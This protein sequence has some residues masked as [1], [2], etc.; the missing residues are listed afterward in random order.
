M[1][2]SENT[3]LLG[4]VRGCLYGGAVG[5]A[6]GAPAEGRRPEE[7]RDRYHEITGFVEPWNGPS[8]L[9]K[10]DGRY[11]DDTHMVQVLSRLYIEEGDHLDVFR[12]AR[13]IVPLI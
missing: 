1:S 4:K 3:A 11:T 8:E 7:I 6:L 10:G 5:D 2:V 13:R 9:G 12:F